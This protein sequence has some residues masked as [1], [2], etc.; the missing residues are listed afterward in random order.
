[1]RLASPFLLLLAVPVLAALFFYLKGAIG[2]EAS[3]KFSDLSLVT[4]AGVRTVSW[5]RLLTALLRGA[6]LLFLIFALARPQTGHGEQEETK[7]VVDLMLSLD[8]SSSMATLDFHPDNRLVAAKLEAKRFIETRENARIG[9]VVFAKNAVTLCPLTTDKGALLSILGQVDMGMLED[10]TAIGVGLAAAVNRLR[11]SE[12]KSKVA[13]LLTDG[14]NNSGEID[15]KTA[16]KIAKEYGVRVYTI[17]MGIEGQAML[18]VRDP[19]FGTTRL[20]RVETQIDEDL[21]REI[22]EPTGGK[23]FRAQDEKALREIFEQ[24][25][26]MEK[27]EIKVQ[28]FT[29]YDDHFRSFVWIG[30]C[31]LLVELFLMNVLF[32]KIP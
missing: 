30:L 1:M 9:L 4:R 20:V 17:G 14:V 13:I 31:I 23:Y 32:S 29:R 6:A 18:P 10:G 15:P 22:A 21:M 2:K 8:T 26:K 25:D 28:K 11:E 19:R 7:F 12:A 27:T 24:I 3:L 16:G 5:R